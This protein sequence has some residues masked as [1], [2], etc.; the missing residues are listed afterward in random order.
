M[1]QE[2]REIVTNS[3]RSHCHALGLA[4]IFEA[5]SVANSLADLA[6]GKSPACAI[7][8]GKQSAERYAAPPYRKQPSQPGA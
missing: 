6:H 4:H 7:G 1:N 2:I 8:R 5:A 3:V